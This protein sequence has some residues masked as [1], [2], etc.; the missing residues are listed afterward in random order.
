[1]KP[2]NFVPFNIFIILVILTKHLVNLTKWVGYCYQIIDT[3]FIW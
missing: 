1:M 2:K 3:K